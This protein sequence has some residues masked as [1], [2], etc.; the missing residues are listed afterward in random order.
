VPDKIIQKI[1]TLFFLVILPINSVFAWEIS[2]HLGVENLTF[3][4]NSLD[5]RQHN[6]YV[7]GVIEPELY[8][9]WD[10]GNQ[11]FAFVPYFR[12]SQ[13]DSRRTHFDIRELTWVKVA[14]TWELRVGIRKLFWGVTESQ[15]LINIIN[16][17]DLVENTDT[18]DKLGQ[19]M[20]NLALIN[21][22]GTLD[23]FLLTGFR[24]RTFPG[25][26]GRIRASPPIDIDN[27]RFEKKG[28]E[29]HLAYAVRW[30]HTIG[31]WDLGFSHF[32]GTNRDPL[33]LP[34]TDKFGNQRLLPYYEMIN[35][36][37]LDLQVTKGSWLWKLE[38]IFR[39]SKTDDYFASTAGFEYTFFDV[40]ETGLDIGILGE[41]L[42][43]SRGQN[44]QTLF[45]DD[46]LVAMRIAFNDVQSTELLAGII[47]DRTSSAKFYNIEA[48][49]RFGDSWKLDMEARF[50]SGIPKADPAHFLR[51][52]DHIRLEVSYHF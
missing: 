3:T 50:F 2:G 49:R 20:I 23:L 17:T 36:T 26:E 19:P 5:N 27:A 52:D 15:H 47:F 6:N 29:R 18:E 42:Y 35:Q 39:S 43:D 13:H 4:Q 51:D 14:E 10:A 46:F 28:I 25:V 41:Y 11:S 37:G 24:E 40:Y 9:E 8:H 34:E 38:A 22:W 1:V 12:Y 7:S 45:E 31:D 32:Y 30:S 16:Q 21:D 48:S 44:F 33:F